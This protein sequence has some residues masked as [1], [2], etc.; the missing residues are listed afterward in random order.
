[1]TGVTRRHIALVGLPGSGKG[2]I[3]KALAARLG[4]RH[5]DIDD[6]VAR[7]TGQTLRQFIEREGEPAF[8]RE[9]L[10]ALEVAVADPMVA[11]IACGGGLFAGD[12][13]RELLAATA[14]TVWLDAPDTVLL[15]RLGDAVVDRPLLAADPPRN[16]RR[17]RR[18]RAAA[19]ATAD[20][21]VDAG[22]DV[23]TVT[24]RVLAA[25]GE[26]DV[27]VDIPGR[28]Y[29]VLI[30]PGVADTVADRLPPTCGRVAVIADRAVAPL[31][32]RV[33]GAVRRTGRTVTMAYIEG[34]EGAKTW[35]RAGRLLRTLTAA[36]LLRDDCV[37]AVGGG[38]IGDLAGFVAGVYMRGIAVIHVPTTLIAMVDSSIGGK[39]GVDL[40]A[41]K[42]LAGVFWQPRALFCDLTALATVPERAQ[43]GACSEII[44]YSLIAD[45][46]FAAVLDG[47]LES[48]L[49]GD[50]AVTTAVVRRCSE[51][52]AD[53]VAGDERETGRR[54]LLNYG[55]TVGHAV[56]AVTKY[57]LWHGE[58]LAI[59]MRVA[60]LLSIRYNGCPPED[61]RWQ[62]EM[63]DRAG[64]DMRPRLD[65]DAVVARTA[66]DKKS[67]A[68]RV[69][70]VLIDRLGEGSGG[71]LIDD[72]DVRAAVAEVVDP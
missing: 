62:N 16:L 49:A 47:V 58:A 34:G 61:V 45:S 31:A 71:H 5:V 29:P 63:L 51:I 68:G 30:G 56:E 54:A 25:I 4:A 35:V 20:H 72:A 7:R 9:E 50:L 33:A 8:R 28:R 59:G 18:A 24:G 48:L 39:T 38:T 12:I 41:G 36:G 64:L 2:T 52:K 55:H 3:A 69:R 22:P 57:A 19:H 44:K 27:W 15:R 66:I 26:A 37:V 23:A 21:H 53:V 70:W 10:L 6:E 67:S 65:P 17:L 14:T 13:A 42:N 46:G 32:R 43:R 60:G 11:V 40:P 1:M